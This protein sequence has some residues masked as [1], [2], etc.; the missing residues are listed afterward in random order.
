MVK[1]ES[2]LWRSSAPT[3][4]SSSVT[5]IRC[6][7]GFWTHRILDY[8][9][10]GGSHKDHWVQLL[11]PHRTIQKSNH[12]FWEHCPDVSWILRRAVFKEGN[13]TL[14]NLFFC[15]TTC[16]VKKPDVQIELF[17][18]QFVSIAHLPFMALSCGILLSR[19][20]KR[21]ECSLLK[22]RFVSLLGALPTVLRMVNSIISCPQ[23][24]RLPLSF[25][26]LASPSL[27]VKTRSS[28]APLSKSSSI[29]WRIKFSP[30]QSRKLL[31]CLC[32]AL[33]S[34]QQILG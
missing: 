17:V 15:S 25:T 5:S 31:D 32:T 8:P 3:S 20:L 2:D 11:F 9:G 19:P 24:P 7:D 16:S 6:S 1:V 33:L 18:F 27:L 34:L 14:G 28:G 23:W 26:F 29:I 13:S 30:V 12:Y 21:L 10:L 4:C 22:S